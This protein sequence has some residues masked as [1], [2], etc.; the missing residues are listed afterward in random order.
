LLTDP[1]KGIW[2]S[3]AQREGEKIS[4]LMDRYAKGHGFTLLQG[5]E[6]GKKTVTNTLNMRKKVLPHRR[7][8]RT[9]YFWEGGK[10]KKD[11][12][13]RLKRAYIP[14]SR[15]GKKP[16]LSPPQERKGGRGGLGGEKW[17]VHNHPEGG[18]KLE[19]RKGK[20][21]GVHPTGIKGNQK[22][23]GGKDHD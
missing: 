7:K 22:K 20:Q 23:G 19:L 12:K 3:Q 13:G 10:N 16:Y 6:E 17:L 14:K 18:N 9:N 5:V 8:D 15:G 11:H 21:K 4:P 1:I 2:T